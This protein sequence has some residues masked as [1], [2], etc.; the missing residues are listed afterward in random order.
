MQQKGKKQKRNDYQSFLYNGIDTK[1][2]E[3]EFCYTF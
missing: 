1:N 2:I 3:Q